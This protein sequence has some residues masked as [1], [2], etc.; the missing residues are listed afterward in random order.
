MAAAGPIFP[1]YIR[2]KKMENN[3][4]L[5]KALRGGDRQALGQL[6]DQYAPALFGL[7]IRLTQSEQQAT[8]VLQ[9]AFR[10]MWAEAA[11]LDAGQADLFGWAVGITKKLALEA[12][13]QNE[14]FDFSAYQAAHPAGASL[15]TLAREM[16]E[17]HLRI[18]DLAYLHGRSEPD[19]ETEMNI[20]VGTVNTRL[21]VGIRE[22]RRILK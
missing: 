12:A 18:I 22:L 16:D 15:A 2:S 10:Q 5:L 9:A 7:A 13:S 6:Y 17:K 4:D 8:G 1:K 11:R 3:Q 14:Q 19:I 20:P 21:R